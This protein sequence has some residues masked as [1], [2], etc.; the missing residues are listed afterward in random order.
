MKIVIAPDSFKGS[1]S[2]VAAAKIIHQAIV[3]KD[4]AIETIQ[5]PMADGGEGT[6]DA[7]LWI[8]GGEKI[9]CRAEDPLGR[10]IEAVYGWLEQEKTAI[11]ETAA[12]SG[13]P[14]LQASELNPQQ[15]SSYGT[16]Q[17]IKNALD[18]GAERIILGLGGSATIDAGT[19]LFQALGVKFLDE[20]RNEIR[21][22]GGLLHQIAAMDDAGLDTRLA[23][24]KFIVAS[25]VTNQLLGN[26]GAIYVFGPQKGLRLEELASF[27]QGM[28]H[29]AELAARETGK[30]MAKQLGS[31]AAGGIGFLMHT[32][33][34]AEFRSG[35]ELIAELSGLNQQLEG[36]DLVLTAEGRIDGQS[37]F[38]KVPVGIGRLAK[39][40]GVPV[41]AF[42][43]SVGAGH[44][45]L[46]EEGIAAVIPIADGPS[47]LQEA[48]QNSET[49][50]Y[51]AT[52]RMMKIL[53][54]G[55]SI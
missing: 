11:I 47:T 43:G 14:L 17:L 13:L 31:G 33:L 19:G 5:M 44:E 15:A 46:E 48:M 7:V 4:A 12:A 55:K 49:L 9:S 39:K 27:E 18:K 2:S 54:I 37:L 53:E 35:L 23:A 16:G 32:L 51:N 24:V 38:G 3:D 36:A 45:K 42:A 6:V 8:R 50:L 22:V 26:E 30:A 20:D 21:R 28:S 25:D 29:F 40:R 10:P 1:L 52:S 41:I 34:T